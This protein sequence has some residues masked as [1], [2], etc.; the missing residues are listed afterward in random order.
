M[1]K[2]RVTT[3]KTKRDE[4]YPRNNL[5]VN[6]PFKKVP[7]ERGKSF[8]QYQIPGKLSV[9]PREAGD[10][11]IHLNVSIQSNGREKNEWIKF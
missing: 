6:A 8:A 3:S 2:I 7:G 11:A 1:N 5:K 4:W 9:M 10:I